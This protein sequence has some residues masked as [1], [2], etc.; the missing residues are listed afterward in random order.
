MMIE[1]NKNEWNVPQV[2]VFV[3]VNRFIFRMEKSEMIFTLS[4]ETYMFVIH[5][6]VGFDC[7][8]LF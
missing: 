2:C 6:L 4:L 7:L 1:T 8:S 3:C 5:I